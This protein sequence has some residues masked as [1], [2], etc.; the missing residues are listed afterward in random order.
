MLTGKTAVVTGAGAG[1]GAAIA[2]RL[3]AD[4]AS[5]FVTDMDLAA[6]QAVA[7]EIAAQGGAAEALQ[8]DVCS[9][10]TIDAAIDA[11][12]QKG[13]GLDIWVNNAGVSS[14]GRAWDMTEK[15][16]DFNMDINAKGVFLCTVS[17]LNKVFMKQKKGK[18]INIA[19]IAS[20][21]SD[22]MLSAYCASKW[23]VAGYTRTIARE[24]GPYGI[25]ANYICPGPVETG[26]N[27]RENQW[28]ADIQ[29]STPDAVKQDLIDAIPLGRLVCPE[30]VAA[31]AAFLA[32]DNAGFI[33][34][35][36]LPVTGAMEA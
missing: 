17:V 10:D 29:G 21:R 11:V 35:A 36:A 13:A 28:S 30:D 26:M 3:A 4:G 32:G 20:L 31:A 16:W 34:G 24:C 12:L 9:K 6:A 23:A 22:P 18:F 1:I 7:G 27:V 25:T 19:S 14:M 5:V 8:L 15:D 2:K 33:N